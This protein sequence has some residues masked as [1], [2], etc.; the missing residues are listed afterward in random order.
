MSRTVC[1]RCFV[2]RD[3]QVIRMVKAKAGMRLDA[4]GFA[5]MQCIGDRG[6]VHLL[7]FFTFTVGLRTCNI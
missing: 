2:L 6:I 5:L 4:E 7:N 3:V 1:S